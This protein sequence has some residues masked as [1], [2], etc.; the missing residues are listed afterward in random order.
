MNKIDLVTGAVAFALIV[1]MFGAIGGVDNELLSPGKGVAAVL[2][3]AALLVVDIR[4]GEAA[5]RKLH[6]RLYLYERREAD[7]KKGA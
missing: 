4:A 3:L 1:L 6:R 2:I 7:E 5:K